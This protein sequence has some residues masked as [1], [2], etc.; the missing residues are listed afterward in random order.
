MKRRFTGSIVAAMALVL[1]L[2]VAPATA[3]EAEQAPTE[4]EVTDYGAEPRQLLRYAWAEGQAETFGIEVAT[5]LSMSMDGVSVMEMELPMA[6]TTD[7]LVVDVR[8]DGSARVEF[9]Y[10]ELDFGDAALSSELIS[11]DDEI[12]ESMSDFDSELDEMTKDFV[13]ITGWQEMDDRGHILEFGVDMPEAFPPELRGQFDQLS[14]SAA[15]GE[16]MPEEPVGLGAKWVSSGSF[17]SAGVALAMDGETEVVALDDTSVTLRRTM[18][19]DVEDA[20]SVF[21]ELPP[22]VDISVEEFVFEGGGETRVEL[23]GVVPD[24]AMGV[25]FRFEVAASSVED[26]EPV[27]MDLGM[28]MTMDMTMHKVTDR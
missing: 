26:E 17:G 19:M 25:V 7:M 27:S 11:S 12:D 1:P 13:G 2:S 22:G 15:S 28:D 3:Q 24:G 14:G 16:P 6:M 5:S 9:V 21:G 10:T 8:E 4:P 20:A 18:T 23:D